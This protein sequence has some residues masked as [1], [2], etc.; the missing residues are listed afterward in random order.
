MLQIDISN[1]PSPPDTWHLIIWT[2]SNIEVI[3]DLELD[4]VC[5]VCSVEEDVSCT[6]RLASSPQYISILVDI[7]KWS[8][9]YVHGCYAKIALPC[10]YSGCCVWGKIALPSRHAY[11]SCWEICLPSRRAHVL[12]ALRKKLPSPRV[13]PHI[14]VHDLLDIRNHLDH[15]MQCWIQVHFR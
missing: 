11:S 8:S 5:T 4:Y 2:V 6:K 7:G 14:C 3:G 15:I 12:A 1:I 13:I 9:P 10:T